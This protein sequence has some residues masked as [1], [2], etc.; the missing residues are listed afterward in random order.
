MKVVAAIILIAI[1]SVSGEP[2]LG[3]LLAGSVNYANGQITDIRAVIK[4]MGLNV[5]SELLSDEQTFLKKLLPFLPPGLLNTFIGSQQSSI[6]LIQQII[7]FVLDLLQRLLQAI[8]QV[9]SK[10]Q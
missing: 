4:T 6:G 9:L 7:D 2:S 1:V 3:D 10:I 8:A 5:E